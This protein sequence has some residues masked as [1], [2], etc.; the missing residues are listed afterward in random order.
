MVRGRRA[1]TPSSS[2]ASCHLG[3]AEVSTVAPRWGFQGTSLGEGKGKWK[4]QVGVRE[5]GGLELH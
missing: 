2:T 4:G 3:V 1:G 5:K